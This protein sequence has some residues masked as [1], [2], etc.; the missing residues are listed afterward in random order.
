MSHPIDKQR[1]ANEKGQT[2]LLVAVSLFTLIA[3]AALAIDLTT[4]Y[5]ARGEMQRAAD[6]AALAARKR[7]WKPE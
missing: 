5:A 4:L 2:L 1:H 6:A 3:M 7:S